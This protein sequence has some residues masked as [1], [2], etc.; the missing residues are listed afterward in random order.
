VSQKGVKKG[1]DTLGLAQNHGK[2][3]SYV[4][5]ESNPLPSFV[6]PPSIPIADLFF[7]ADK[8]CCLTQKK[9]NWENFGK[10]SLINFA[11]FWEKFCQVFFMS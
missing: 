5:G 7:F 10:I 2:G 3:V 11:N 1:K 8:F 9:K 4:K 6:D